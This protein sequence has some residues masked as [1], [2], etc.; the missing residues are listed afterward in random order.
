MSI[1]EELA[2]RITKAQKDLAALEAKERPLALRGWR[3]DF[4]GDSLHEQYTPVSAG[5]GSS[6]ALQDNA[7]GG[8]YR[9]TSG[10]AAGRYHYLWLGNAVDGFD[11]LDADYGWVQIVRMAVSATTNFSG[12]F[13]ARDAA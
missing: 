6:G 8:I 1:E 9:L 5:A 4:L 13:G 7:H 11:T 3:D 10:P 12:I 2:A